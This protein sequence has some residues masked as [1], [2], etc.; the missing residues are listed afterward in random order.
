MKVQNIFGL[1]L[2]GLLF[3]FSGCISGEMNTT[4]HADGGVHQLVSLDKIGLLAN[5]NC[6]SLKNMMQASP[7]IQASDLTY[8]DQVCR[9]TSSAVIVEFDAP[10][11]DKRNSVTIVER[12][13]GN[14]LRYETTPVSITT[15]TITM[16]SK[17]TS[18]NGELI[19]E[20]TVVFKGIVPSFDVDSP[21][22]DQTDTNIF[23]ESKMP[24]QEPMP[25][26]I[27]LAV[28]GVII[29]V[30]CAGYLQLRKK[31][32]PLSAKKNKR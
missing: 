8:F 16:P 31:K 23:V 28:I 19:N 21:S 24:K 15:N 5:A 20:N 3:L 9:E 27:I 22:G 12:A 7:D 6:H 25:F 1:I 18:H 17:V 14:Y 30:I 26:I 10:Y 4:V 29:V 2:V 32:S 11:G 13:D